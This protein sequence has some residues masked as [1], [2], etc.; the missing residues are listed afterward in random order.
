M[1]NCD[2]SISMFMKNCL[3]IVVMFSCCFLRSLAT[4][5]QSQ[6]QLREQWENKDFADAIS[7][8][9]KQLQQNPNSVSAHIQLGVTYLAMDAY[10]AA[11]GEYQQ[12]IQLSPENFSAHYGLGLAYYAQDKFEEAIESHKRA[13]AL[14]P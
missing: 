2:K 7:E 10:E 12:A 4:F 9:K 6:F 8:Y 3:V 14:A 1:R 13:I 11:A 5:G